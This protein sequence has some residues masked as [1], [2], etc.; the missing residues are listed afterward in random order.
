LSPRSET[1]GGEL[2]PR[3]QSSPLGAEFTPRGKLH[4]WGPSSP[5]GTKFT[6]RGQLYPWGQTLLLKSCHVPLL[7]PSGPLRMVHSSIF[8]KC[9]TSL[10]TSSSVWGRFYETVSAE[11]YGLKRD[12]VQFSFIIM[13]SCDFQRYIKLIHNCHYY[14]GNFT[15]VTSGWKFVKTWGTKIY[16]KTFWPKWEFRKIGPWCL[17]S[18]PTKSL[19]FS[20]RTKKSQSVTKSSLLSVRHLGIRVIRCYCERNRPKCSP[21]HFLSN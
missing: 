2:S 14:S 21:N 3:G 15:Y 8:P 16:P 13:N 6:P 7:Y 10:R 17:L 20:E 5:L 19:R 18:M 1:P 11:I 9:C 12:W 4:P